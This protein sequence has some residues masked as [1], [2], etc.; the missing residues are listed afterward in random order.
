MKLSTITGVVL[1]MDGVLWRGDERL[2]GVELIFNLL[3]AR[4]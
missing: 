1:D 2:P 3:H 4:G